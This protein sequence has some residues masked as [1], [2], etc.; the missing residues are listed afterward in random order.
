MKRKKGEN[1]AVRHRGGERGRT[2][3]ETREEDIQVT[4]CV[5]C[6]VFVSREMMAAAHRASSQRLSLPECLCDLAVCLFL[7]LP[8]PC[9]ALAP[10]VN[11]RVDATQLGTHK[12]LHIP[13]NNT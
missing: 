7:P 13:A 9:I 4:R 1:P 6:C 5:L 8:L 10:V 2:G 11:E 3:G 12:L